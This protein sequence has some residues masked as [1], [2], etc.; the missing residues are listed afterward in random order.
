MNANSADTSGPAQATPLV[1]AQ[2]KAAL[3]ADADLQVFAVVMGE[4]V[5]DLPARLAAADVADFDCLL[6]GALEPDVQRNAPHIVRLKPESAFTDWLLFEAD[7]AF[8][9]WG[10]LVRSPAR[11]LVLRNHLRGLLR[12]TLPGGHAVALDWMDPTIFQAVAPLFGPAEITAFFGPVRTI[13]IPGSTAWRHAELQMG[14]LAQRE[15]PL[16]KAA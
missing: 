13:T 14:R 10:L 3:W 12:A 11:L 15:V 4:R 7:A 5:S 6:P 9:E 1:A 8:G 2:H 16:Q